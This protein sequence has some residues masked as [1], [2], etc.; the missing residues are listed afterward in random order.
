[1]I[2]RSHPSV[3]ELLKNTA[4]MDAAVDRAA[5]EA[6]LEHARAGCPV[7]TWCDG[8]VVWVQ[9]A[10]ILARYADHNSNP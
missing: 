7:A 9:P 8:Q 2:D 10:E 5:R 1:M 4:A 3:Y 6:V